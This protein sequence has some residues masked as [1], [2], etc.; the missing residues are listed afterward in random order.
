MVHTLDKHK[1]VIHADVRALQTILRNMYSNAIKFTPQ[2][3]EVSLEIIDQKNQVQIKVSDTGV[4][5]NAEQLLHLFN[6]NKENTLGTKGEKGSGLGAIL[7]YELIKMN[8]GDIKVSS[9]PGEG[10]IVD[11]YLPKAT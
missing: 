2:G 3:G 6:I 1:S 9:T 7:T 4:G 8:K 10:T 11:I 5:M